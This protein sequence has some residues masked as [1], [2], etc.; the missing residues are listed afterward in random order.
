MTKFCTNCGKELKDGADICLN[1]GKVVNNN[2]DNQKKNN[3]IGVLG[4]ILIFIF[5]FIYLFFVLFI[6][7]AIIDEE[8]L[9]NNNLDDYIEN[10]VLNDKKDN[11]GFVGDTLY[12]ND[13]ELTLKSAKVYDELDINGDIKQPKEGY[14]YLVLLFD[15]RNIGKFNY[16]F[17]IYNFVGY[18]DGKEIVLLNI[19]GVD[20]YNALNGEIET[21]GSL[22]GNVIYEVN[23]D[24]MSFDIDYAI[25]YE[26]KSVTFRVTRSNINNNYKVEF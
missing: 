1:C 10:N 3:G 5:C 8:E 19:D 12:C 20:D 9:D 25:F 16:D 23:K 14:E 7:I 18:E 6:F 11:I 22:R 24:W 15:V 21:R 4:I 2:I 17:N 13:L 26:K